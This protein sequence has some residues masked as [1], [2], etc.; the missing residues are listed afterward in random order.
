MKT[1]LACLIMLLVSAC[2]MKEVPPKHLILN[3]KGEAKGEVK[4]VPDSVGQDDNAGGFLQADCFKADVFDPAT[5]KKLGTAQDCLT[6]IGVGTNTGSGSGLQVVGTTLFE[7]EGKGRLVVQG[8]TT[9]QPVNWPTSNSNMI[10]SHTTGANSP[11]FSTV[12][13]SGEFSNTG[14]FKGKKTR[15]RLSGLVDLKREP[16]GIITFDCLFVVTLE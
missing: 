8:L 12:A 9:V 11:K 14:D 2:A 15:T 10:F 3:F 1:I 16:E 4:Q 5:D 7:L 13:S 6:I